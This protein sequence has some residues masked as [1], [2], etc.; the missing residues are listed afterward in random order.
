MGTVSLPKPRPRGLTAP[1]L[2]GF[3]VV[4]AWFGYFAPRALAAH[5]GVPA[6]SLAFRV[7]LL[8]A[9][10]T[11]LICVWN[12]LLTP[13]EGRRFAKIHKILGRV[14]L[15]LSLVGTVLG[16]VAAWTDEGIPRGTAIGLSVVGVF[17][18][19]HTIRGYR[20]I[21]L[22]QSAVGDEK[23]RY[24][25]EHR[26]A[27]TRLYYGCCLGPAW[28]RIPSWLGLASPGSNVQFVGI[29]PPIVCIN[30]AIRTYEDKSF[31]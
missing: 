30:M 9:C 8:C 17:Q 18:F 16:Y 29:I 21:K 24:V 25:D 4:V 20:Y 14:A 13:S 1:W 28:F 2:F 11:T 22:A 26:K 19:K 5:G 27:M 10:T 31:F 6:M 3:I 12:T 23:K 7:H 15:V